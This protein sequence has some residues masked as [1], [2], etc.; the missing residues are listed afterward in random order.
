MQEN[1]LNFVRLSDNVLI[2]QCFCYNK[3]AKCGD[4]I[5]WLGNQVACNKFF[6]LLKPDTKNNLFY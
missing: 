6:S 2:V 4:A 1:E 3:N 5:Y